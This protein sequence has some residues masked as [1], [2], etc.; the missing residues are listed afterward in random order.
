MLKEK[1]TNLEFCIKGN[2]SL[3]GKNTEFN[4]QAKVEGIHHQQTCPEIK[5]KIFIQKVHGTGQKFG[6]P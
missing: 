3:Q 2:H 6:S 4:R 5:T 1:N